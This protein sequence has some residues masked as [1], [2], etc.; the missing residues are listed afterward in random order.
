MIVPLD[1][2]CEFAFAT[3]VGCLPQ[4]TG[5]HRTI[6]VP[7]RAS[8]RSGNWSGKAIW[9]NEKKKKNSSSNPTVTFCVTSQLWLNGNQACTSF[10]YLLAEVLWTQLV[11][12]VAVGGCWPAVNSFTEFAETSVGVYA[13]NLLMGWKQQVRNLAY[14]T[15]LRK[16]HD[17]YLLMNFYV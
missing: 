3:E 7:V 16:R 10:L 5:H 4:Q 13:V 2:T 11:R 17:H 1:M 12:V 6:T 14:F 9:Q 15:Q 8:G